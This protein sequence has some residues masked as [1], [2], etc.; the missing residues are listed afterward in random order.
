MDEPFDDSD[1]FIARRG[2][3]GEDWHWEHAPAEPA[4][5][6]PGRSG[7]PGR[8]ALAAAWGRAASA[9][10]SLARWLTPRRAPQ[11]PQ[12]PE[13]PPVPPAQA[14]AAALGPP[15]GP[16]QPPAASAAT[17]AQPIEVERD[18]GSPIRWSQL[19]P[20]IAGRRPRVAV[21]W[22]RVGGERPSLKGLRPAAVP[23]ES[24]SLVVLFA[25]LALMAAIVAGVIIGVNSLDS[26]GDNDGGIV[27]GVTATP[28]LAPSFSP[29]A[30]PSPGA[31]AV[32]SATP[33]ATKSATPSPSA[34]PTPSP[35]PTLGQPA[36]ATPFPP[37]NPQGPMAAAFWSN[38]SHFWWFGELP[39]QLGNYQEGQA[40]PFLLQWDA[41]PGETYQL[42]ISYACSS[43]QSAAAIDY[44]TGVEDWGDEILTADHGP[45]AGL[46][47]SAISVPDTE[48]FLPDN[49]SSG[50]LTLYGGKFTVL[51][52]PPS[53][54]GACSGQRSV[55]LTVRAIA[56]K[57][58]F[59]AGAHLGAASVYGPGRGA[60]SATSAMSLTAAVDGVGATNIRIDP[61]AIS[62]TE[63]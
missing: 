46:P 49:S 57:V 63:H 26:G 52:S 60:A 45:G 14:P 39:G 22:S 50:L 48:G 38:V 43:G 44:L 53:P 6:K 59:L 9:F 33:A 27:G 28:T 15:S 62:N 41:A 1:H 30:T 31:S 10:G 35:S 36:S 18:R 40:V 21:P 29:A 51:P 25:S 58:T 23:E 3:Q 2:S 12:S 55:S 13:I 17:T 11:G 37:N 32:A 5:R 61:G 24:G 7:F 20:R 16:S 42:R 54:S 56:G 34:T 47:D 4:P 19:V 8:G